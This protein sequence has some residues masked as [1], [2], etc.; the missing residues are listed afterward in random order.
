MTW[1]PNHSTLYSYAKG[2]HAPR[3]LLIAV[4]GPPGSGK[5]TLAYPLIDRI[6]AL[7]HTPSSHPA[8]INLDTAV[9][10]PSQPT[11]PGQIAISVSLDGWHLPLSALT[12]TTLAR[13]GAVFTFDAEGY[14]RFVRRVRADDESEVEFMEFDHAIK[15]PSVAPVPVRRENRIVLIEGLYLL[16]DEEGWRDVVGLYDMTVYVDVDEKVGRRRVIERNFRAGILPTLEAMTAQGEYQQGRRSP[17]EEEEGGGLMMVVDS[18]DMLNFREVTS[19][20][21][22]AMYEVRSEED[23]RRDEVEA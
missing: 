6:N 13:R 7:L 19:K 12:P 17:I 14:Q 2:R 23:P 10:S 1:C 8:H 11:P 16:L 18:N 15:D 4:A 5:S 21:L 20:R 3:R 22:P 9:A